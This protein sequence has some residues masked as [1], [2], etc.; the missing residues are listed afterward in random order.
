MTPKREV[1]IYDLAKELNIST[2]TISR[3]LNNHPT[4]SK[5]TKKKIN[6]LAKVLGYQQNN[7]ASNL[8]KNKTNTIGVIIHELNS[9]FIISVLSGIEKVT[10][11]AQY[12]IIIGHSAEKATRE[13]ANA[14]NLFHKRVD[15]IIASLAYDTEN[16][17][18]YEPY[19]KKGIPIVFFDRV[20]KDSAGIK[21]VIDNY[22]AGYE[23][24]T[25][26]IQ[27]GCKRLVHITGSLLQ[28]VYAD[29]WKGFQDVLAANNLPCG[30][31]QLIVNDLSEKAS[32]E[33][34]AHLLAME[35]RPDGLFIANDLSAAVCMQKLKEGGVRVPQDMAI[36]GFNNDLVSRIV[37]PALTTIN[38]TGQDIGE[39][40]AKSL[41]NQ[42][43]G[44]SLAD[45]SYTIT[46]QSEL[47]IRASSL[48]KR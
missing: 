13:A 41:I 42:L 32:I 45:T 46:L 40:A 14:L 21:V 11:A 37:E 5:K 31:E 47:I 33:A 10:T 39:I 27:Q 15:G 23:A 24:T 7:F 29:R 17:D 16:L 44:D 43:N 19:L 9:R 25:H 3:A 35:N 22:K 20:K 34:A 6:E 48:K 36:V 28:N 12:D 38:Y 2:A 18:H 30:P 4:V 26:L 8:R 1:T